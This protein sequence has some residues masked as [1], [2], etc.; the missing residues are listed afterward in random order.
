MVIIFHLVGCKVCMAGPALDALS[1]CL[2]ASF[3]IGTL[4]EPGWSL[5]LTIWPPWFNWQDEH[6]LWMPRL[7]LLHNRNV[8][9]KAL[10]ARSTPLQLQQRGGLSVFFFTFVRCKKPLDVWLQTGECRFLWH[11]ICGARLGCSLLTGI[12]CGCTSTLLRQML[13]RPRIET[14]SATASSFC[15]HFP[16][17]SKMPIPT[18]DG[19][20]GDVE[21]KNVPFRRSNGHLA[22]LGNH[23]EMSDLGFTLQTTSILVCF[24]C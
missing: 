22:P 7:K 14:C 17:K 1:A 16:L 4:S 12:R 19:K 24:L 20:D 9:A 23:T 11:F 2:E 5:W 15:T 21:L 13:P 8:K 3:K 6:S 10:A 18:N